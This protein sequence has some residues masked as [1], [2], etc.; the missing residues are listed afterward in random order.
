MKAGEMEGLPDEGGWSPQINLGVPVL[1]PADYVTDLD[2]RLGLYRRLSGLSKKV[3]LE[4]FAAEL[5]DRFGKLPPEVDTLLRIVRIKAMCQRAGIAKLDGGPK[6]A[7]LQFHG[8]KFANPAGLVEYL[9]KQNGLGRV[10][11]NKIIIRRDWG[12]DKAKING[13]YIIARDLAVLAT[14]AK[15]AKPNS[16]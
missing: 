11:D 4:G 10:K 12:S 3:E 6:G 9:H 15:K 13:A 1:I 5:I 16:G 7:V 8:D 14:P 2:V